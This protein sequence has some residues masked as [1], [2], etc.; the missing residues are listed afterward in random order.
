MCTGKL[1]EVVMVKGVPDCKQICDFIPITEE[2]EKKKIIRFFFT[3]RSVLNCCQNKEVVEI[4]TKSR[5]CRKANLH[6][7]LCVCGSSLILSEIETET[8]GKST[9]TK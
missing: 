2:E 3:F 5:D 9:S 1:C 8:G 7:T 4:G 6:S